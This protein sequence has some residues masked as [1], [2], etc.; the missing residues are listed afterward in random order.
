M[1]VTM[2]HGL[3]GVH[4]DFYTRVRSRSELHQDIEGDSLF[5]VNSEFSNVED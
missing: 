1:L 4:D 3:L 2:Y 5:E